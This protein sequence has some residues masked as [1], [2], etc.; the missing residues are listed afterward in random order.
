M[1]AY[2]WQA[3]SK[4]FSPS[5]YLSLSCIYS[6]SETV[7]EHLSKYSLSLGCFIVEESVMCAFKKNSMVGFYFWHI[8]LELNDPAVANLHGFY[9]I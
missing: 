7:V 5:L 6:K 2:Y 1:Q 3:N 8:K 4:K 9:F